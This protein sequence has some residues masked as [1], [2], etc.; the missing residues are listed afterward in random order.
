MFYYDIFN[1]VDFLITALFSFLI[2]VFVLCMTKEPSKMRFLGISFII[3]FLLCLVSFFSIKDSISSVLL[4]YSDLILLLALF[5]IAYIKTI[6]KT[7][8]FFTIFVLIIPI[9][10]ILSVYY[11]RALPNILSKSYLVLPV[12]LL[13]G[14]LYLFFI[15]KESNSNDIYFWGVVFLTLSLPIKILLEVNSFSRL[16]LLFK[17]SAFIAFFLYFYY[18]IYS[19]MMS[20]VIEA[21]KKLLT[22]N[23]SLNL[24][25]KKRVFEI[26]Q[27]NQKLVNI[28]KTDAL[29]KAL[30]KKTIMDAIGD[31]ITSKPNTIFS[32]FMFDIDNFKI[33]NDTM[34][35][36]VG[37]KC[38]KKV[39]TIAFNSIRDI[40][41]LGRYGGDEFIVLLPGTTSLQAKIIAERFRKRVDETEPPHFTISIGIS[42][43]PSDGA[44]VKD[45]IAIADDGLYISKKK[46]KNV[47][48]H[49]NIF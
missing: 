48:S 16:S 6:T 13:L 11:F 3:P 21:D 45:L 7:N 28:S 35:H 24:E 18:E 9:I 27:S 46:G 26:E 23:K 5:F 10:L 4:I 31:L 29:T 40:D 33:V 37:D 17:L 42:T 34:G 20:K 36:I 41:S 38:I 15:K 49:K 14:V 30:N 32:I 39:A 1:Q 43:F 19:S 12:F 25:V 2:F 22:I 8:I 47:V 44:S